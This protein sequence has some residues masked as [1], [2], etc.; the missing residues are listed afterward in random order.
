MIHSSKCIKARFA[1]QNLVD[2]YTKTWPHYCQTCYG[3]GGQSYRY[4]PSPRGVSLASGY[5]EDFEP[6]PDC[7]ESGKC[8]RCFQS[9]DTTQDECP[10]CHLDFTRPDGL[11]EPP[12]CL[13][14]ME[15]NLYE[16]P[17]M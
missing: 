17:E 1:H 6:C 9:C 5:F 4:D 11:P 13:C 14:W 10:H 2:E 12:E 7:I 16:M 3:W 15:D 8:P